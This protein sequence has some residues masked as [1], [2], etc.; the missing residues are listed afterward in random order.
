MKKLNFSQ[1]EVLNGGQ[2]MVD[3]PW[4]NAPCAAESDAAYLSAL[5]I[6]FTSAIYP[7]GLVAS[8]SGFFSSVKSFNDCNNKGYMVTY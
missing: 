1:M 8:I 3:G 4:R 5:G 7:V 2:I 6:L